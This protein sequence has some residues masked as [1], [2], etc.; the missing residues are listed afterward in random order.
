VSNSNFL[1]E[2][3]FLNGPDE[4]IK[5]MPWA[6]PVIRAVMKQALRIQQARAEITRCNVEVRRLHTAICD[7]EQTFVV[8]LETL[9]TSGE[10]IYPAVLDY[11]TRRRH[12]NNNILRKISQIYLH[13]RF[14]GIPLP[15]IQKGRTTRVQTLPPVVGENNE[16]E[17]VG[18][19]LSDDDEM[20]SEVNKIVDYISTV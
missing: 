3:D 7:E 4:Q 19:D 13:K 18:E 5:E 17:N 8:V 9:K 6:Q 1:E 15:G 14:T 2:F 10:A 20:A 11:C 12:V 16:C